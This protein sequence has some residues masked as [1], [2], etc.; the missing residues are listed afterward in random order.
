MPKKEISNGSLSDYVRQHL[1]TH[2]RT[3]QLRS[4]EIAP[5]E[6][7]V[8]ADLGISRGIVREG[9]RA[10]KAAGILEISNGRAPRVGRISEAGIGQLLQHAISTEQASIEQVLDLRAAIEIRAAELAAAHRTEEHVHALQE[11]VKTMRA[12]KKK[13]TVFIESDARFHQIIALATGNPLFGLIWGAIHVS[14]EASIRTGLKN[15]TKLNELERIILNH[16]RI[17]SAIANQDVQA[18]RKLM[19]VHFEEAQISVKLG[20]GQAPT[21]RP[22]HQNKSRS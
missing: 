3:H 12:A 16:A 21:S 13:P 11:M 2:I 7:Q 9:F 20:D 5:S 14:L 17:A 8:S 22:A 19:I 4:G 1:I 10:L 18:A 15:R 6:M